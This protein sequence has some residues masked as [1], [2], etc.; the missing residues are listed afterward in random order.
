M[1]ERVIGTERYAGTVQPHCKRRHA[2]RDL[3]VRV[4]G[5]LGSETS[6]G[7]LSIIAWKTSIES[8]RAGED[9]AS[10]ISKSAPNEVQMSL[11]TRVSKTQRRM[12]HESDETFKVQTLPEVLHDS[13]LQSWSTAGRLSGRP[14]KVRFRSAQQGTARADGHASRIARG[15]KEAPA[16]AHNGK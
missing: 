13:I 16:V 11:L 6:L 3:R 2:L 14:C 4:A 7:M 12:L 1:R 5:T 8:G 10:R 9:C 15:R